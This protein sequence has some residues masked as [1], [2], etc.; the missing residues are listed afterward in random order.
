MVP[1]GN[2]STSGAP[3]GGPAPERPTVEEAA[4]AVSLARRALETVT[5]VAKQEAEA[6]RAAVMQ[7]HA[8]LIGAKSAALIQAELAL[9]EAKD[10]LPDHP[11]A[12]KRVFRME[13]PR[14]RSWEVRGRPEVRVDGI[15][16]MRRSD[17]V[18]AANKRWG[19]PEIGR[20][21]VRLLNKA[22]KPGLSF[23][24]LERSYRPWQLADDLGEKTGR[25]PSSTPDVSDEGPGSTPQPPTGGDQ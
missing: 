5:T 3:T 22:G 19:L 1:P 21:F 14:G 18:F 6:A 16:E 17:T 13:P 23:D 4:A 24:V 9:R 25:D 12:G 8:E 20:P 10:R 2:T 11:W 15:V 7:R